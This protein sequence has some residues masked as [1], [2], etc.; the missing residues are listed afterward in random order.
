MFEFCSQQKS[1]TDF[2]I[3]KETVD[4]VRLQLT[5]NEKTVFG[6]RMSSD[7]IVSAKHVFKLVNR[8]I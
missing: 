7:S 1:K 4:L 5:D 6:K 8:N 3:V 2:F